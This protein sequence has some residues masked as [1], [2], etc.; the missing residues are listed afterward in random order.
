[1]DLIAWFDQHAGSATVVLT[2]VLVAVTGYYAWVTGRIAD[3]TRTMAVAT[4][5]SV[6]Q[7]EQQRY[8][9]VRPVV[10]LGLLSA[11]TDSRPS[12]LHFVL[13]LTNVGVGPAFD[14][15]VTTADMVDYTQKP[16]ISIPTPEPITLGV[17]GVYEILLDADPPPG[18]DKEKHLRSIGERQW[19]GL[20]VVTYRDVYDRG[21]ST[22]AELEGA[23]LV[24]STGYHGIHIVSQTFEH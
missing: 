11:G 4:R 6:E 23:E 18:S 1:V 8:E 20:L 14:V 5:R 12:V 17:G 2:G 7:V 9:A 3:G 21:L 19:A 22:R 24:D 15:R 13:R 16:R 10:A